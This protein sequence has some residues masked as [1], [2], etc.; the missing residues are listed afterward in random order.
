MASKAPI[1]TALQRERW[2]P[3]VLA[4]LWV[5]AFDLLQRKGWF[6]LPA[7][8]KDAYLGALLS[9]GGVFTGFMAT[10]KTLL[11]S[12]NDKTYKRLKAS[13]YDADLLRYLAEA[14][15]GSMALCATALV[16]FHL[17]FVPWLCALLGGI[18]VFAIAAI[19]RIAHIAT[20]L[21]SARS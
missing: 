20:K 6:V 4:A 9:L 12:L 8:S 14:L 18:V 3:W 7:A 16:G 10:L 19:I 11:F 13:G 1:V 17:P 2:S 5:V 15:W 21:L